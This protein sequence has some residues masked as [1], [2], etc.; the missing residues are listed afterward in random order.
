M[1][2]RAAREL[3]FRVA[4]NPPVRRRRTNGARL[5][6]TVHDCTQGD[7]PQIA[8]QDEHTDSGDPLSLIGPFPFL[9]RAVQEKSRDAGRDQTQHGTSRQTHQK[10]SRAIVAA[11]AWGQGVQDRWPAT[12][13]SDTAEKMASQNYRQDNGERLI[14]ESATRKGHVNTRLT[15]EASMAI[16]NTGTRTRFLCLCKVFELGACAKCKV[17]SAGVVVALC[18]KPVPAAPRHVV[19]EGSKSRPSLSKEKRAAEK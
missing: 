17:Q 3:P 13:G 15:Y 9:S 4:P 7:G 8:A 19:V 10:R 5:V 6:V 11:C 14:Q 12:E 1:R 16:T 2:H 18:K